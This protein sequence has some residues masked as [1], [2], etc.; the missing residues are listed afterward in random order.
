[1]IQ[2]DQLR[3]IGDTGVTVS[4]LGVGTAPIGNL[5]TAVSDD[6]ATEMLGRAEQAGIRWF[7][8]APLYGHGLAEQRLGAFLRHA[9]LAARTISTKVGRVLTP[10]P[11]AIP[12]PHFVDPLPNRPDFDYSSRGIRSALSGSLDRLGIA[13]VDIALLHDVDRLTHAGVH[14][15]L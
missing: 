9:P 4:A 6:S 5:F 7:D 8:T 2:P 13:S 12:P 10:A 15:A 14:R 11:G 3:T 1:M